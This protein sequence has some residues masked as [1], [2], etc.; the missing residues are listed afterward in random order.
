MAG[1]TNYKI[2]LSAL[3]DTAS[4]QAQIDKISKN[5]KPIKVKTNV[6]DL[7]KAKTQ[8][9]NVNKATKIIPIITT[10]VMISEPISISKIEKIRLIN[11][12]IKIPFLN[13]FSSTLL[14]KP[15]NFV[16]AGYTF[17]ILPPSS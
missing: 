4:V 17:I 16:L 5:I 9:D 1:N 6:D 3:I 10:G 8:T 2:L 13:P 7:K 11:K 15:L 14:S 12:F